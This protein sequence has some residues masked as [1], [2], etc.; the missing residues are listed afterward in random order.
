[1]NQDHFI[2]TTQE[3]NTLQNP[4]YILMLRY[5]KYQSH[6]NQ[7]NKT[8]LTIAHEINSKSK[9]ALR[10]LQ[11]HIVIKKKKKKKKKEKENYHFLLTVIGEVTSGL[12]SSSF[13]VF[14]SLAAALCMN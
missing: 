6:M 4:K 3:S 12:T 2:R 13:L 1:M 9:I 7:K 11:N 14:S 5:A 8:K 10:P